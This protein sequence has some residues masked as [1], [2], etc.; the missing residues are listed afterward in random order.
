MKRTLALVLTLL[1]LVTAFTPRATAA[2]GD[3]RASDI[4]TEQIGGYTW[5]KDIRITRNAAEDIMPQVTCDQ[6]H[7]SHIVWQ[8]AGYWTRTYDRTGQP[9]SKETFITSHVVTGYGSPDM[10]PLGPQVAI[11]NNQNIHVVWDDGWQ[12]VFYQKFDADANAI[13]GVINVG[14]SDSQ[15]SH[16]P[17][18]TVDAINNYV[19]IG[20]EDYEYQCED[21]VYDKYD[22][23]QK[24]LVNEVSIS[25]DVS[26]HCEHNTLTSDVNGYIHF[27]LGSANGAWWRKVDQNGVARGSSVNVMT[28]QSYKL[29]DPAV[30]PDGSVHCVW[31][32]AGTI[33]YTRMDNNGTILN[34]DI[35]ISKNGVSPGPPRIAACHEENTVYIVWH[36]SR[37]GNIEIH[38]AKMEQGKFGETPENYRLTRNPAESKYPRVAIDPD[39]N[40]HVGWGDMRDGNWEIYYKFMFNFKLELGVVNI[41]ELPSMYFFHP[42]ETKTLHMFLQNQGGL[43]DDYRATLSYDAWATNAGWK[44]FLDNTEF[45]RV[46]GNSKAYLNLTMTAPLAANAGDK[47]NVSINA[48]SLSSKYEN[49]TL[50]WISFIIVEKDVSLVCA[51]PTKLIDSGGT[52]Y[53]NLNVANI[54]DVK[55]SYKI[56]STLIPENAGWTV[57]IDKN[58]VELNVDQATNFTVKVTA[59]EE[60]KANENGTIYIR[61]Q[62]MTDASVWDGKK[63]MA[64]IN[65]TFRLELETLVPNKWVDP[66]ASVDFLITV[67]NV[68]NMQGKVSVYVSSSD[69]RTG[70][71][72]VL[73]RETVFLAGG[74]Q[75]VIKL[76]VTAPPN[77]LA[78]SR[79]VVGVHAV[80]ADFSSRGDV[81]VSALVNRIYGLAQSVD[82]AELSVSPGTQATFLLEITNNGNGNE[83]VDLGSS[84]VPAGWFVTYE[85]QKIEVRNIVLLPKETKVL[86][87]IVKT[88]YDALAGRS[89]PVAVLLDDA[90]TE[91]DVPLVTKVAQYY[92]VDLT[93][94]M[95][96]AEGPPM[97][98][99][100]Y[101]LAVKNQGN[102]DDVFAL[103][104]GNLP[105][106]NWVAAFYDFAGSA[107]TEMALRA[108]E[109]RDVELR[110]HVPQGTGTTAP[111]E[112][113]ARATSS[114]AINDDVKLVLDVKLPDLKV[115]SITYTPSKPKAL[116]PCVITVRIQNDGNFA[117][118]NVVV[119]L[120]D[121]S[122]EVGREFIT[123]VTESSNATASFTWVPTGGRHTLTYTITNDVPEVTMEN[124]VVTNSKTVQ[125]EKQIPGPSA[126]IVMLAMLLVVAIAALARVRRK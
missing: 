68:G 20:H 66:G 21:I 122:R 82:P 96:R 58:I 34:R 76:T 17:A 89:V 56:I 14:N 72:A 43:P 64:L 9:L 112:F 23:N 98:I 44:F 25:N 103:Q 33:Y 114:G 22:Q 126:A 47:I 74:E 65:P 71:G 4:D 41:A 57:K 59:P 113:F 87:A 106:S 92:G 61:V 29:V 107:L 77:A 27:G 69:P 19:H 93:S 42:N 52:I 5:T 12:N 67:R 2:A 24:C 84:Q 15:P 53:F 120:K 78:G 36:D 109:K 55:D 28:T 31:E 70:W 104:V 26:S 63:L 10:Y 105:A 11:D 49:E 60:A 91:Y 8:R 125:A 79:Q 6:F 117:A 101:R 121:G 95:Y 45:H 38:Y 48:Q 16:V 75:Q 39:D 119:M 116:V 102:G 86:S 99:V 73:D 62:S 35:V 51:K 50:A 111:I 81:E 100:N 46:P 90:G 97:G 37:D 13:S 88:P 85:L 118:E 30:T 83:N 40:V 110:L 3:E 1:M 124:N 18:V 80:S 108:G 123:T 7:N 94:S 54:G 32:D 115:Q